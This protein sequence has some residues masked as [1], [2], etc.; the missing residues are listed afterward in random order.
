MFYKRLFVAFFL[1]FISIMAL[2]VGLLWLIDPVEIFG[3]PII[4]GF[5][6][7][8]VREGLVLDVVKPYQ[9]I[10]TR[11]DVLYIGNS[12]VYV[13]LGPVPGDNVKAYNMGQSSMSMPDMLDYLKFC[14]MYHKP[15]VIY[16]GLD[17][18]QFGKE[19][20]F[21]EREGY[22]KDRLNNLM[23]CKTILEQYYYLLQDGIMFGSIEYMEEVVKASYTSSDHCP[24]FYA[25]CDL[26][27][28]LSDGRDQDIYDVVLES[29]HEKYYRWEYEPQSMIKFKEI[30]TFLNEQ[31]VKVVYFFNPISKDLLDIQ[32]INGLTSVY[33]S[34][35][36]EVS[37]FV[38]VTDFATVND[39]TSDLSNFYDPSHYRIRAGVKILENL[40]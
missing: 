38:E 29:F 37:D 27:R 23:S 40:H 12:R 22:S 10:R 3:S 15:K 9:Y 33:S 24:L 8:K 35:K 21:L 11:P 14:C 25:G 28:G 34:I 7:Q 5:N 4:Q 1:G 32:D 17:I 19:N 20:Y 2:A 31:D 13:G 16:I 26:K 6:D 30:V 39:I 36:K 18:E